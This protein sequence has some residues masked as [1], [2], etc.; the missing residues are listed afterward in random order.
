LVQAHLEAQKGVASV[1]PFLFLYNS[2]LSAAT[3]TPCRQ[4]TT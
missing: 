3:A 1:T 2:S 4:Y